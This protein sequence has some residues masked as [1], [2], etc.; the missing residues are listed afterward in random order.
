MTALR[1]RPR[2]DAGV[3]LPELL[4]TMALLGLLT[5]IVMTLVATS[6]RSFTRDRAATESAMTASTGMNELTRVI[7]SGTTLRPTGVS[8]DAP[9][10]LDARANALT[11]Y[12]Y[13]DTSS[14]SPRPM[15]ARFSIDGQRRVVETRWLATTSASPWSF[16]SSPSSSRPI[17]R[18][19]PTGA[20][21]LFRYFDAEG[22]ELVPPANGSNMSEA[23]R[24]LV[25]AVQIHLTVQADGTGRADAVEMQNTVSIPNL[26]ISRIRP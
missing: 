19:V 7:R 18:S 24:R 5:A 14:S 2:G 15:Q 20:P 12:A 26:G 17:A 3:S 8:Q 13:I 11:I 21:A 1:R 25:A 10:F 6:S 22:D 9:V 16:Q 4:V 23:D